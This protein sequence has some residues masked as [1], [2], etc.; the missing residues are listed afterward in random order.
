MLLYVTVTTR[1][2]FTRL[3]K[4]HVPSTLARRMEESQKL[5]ATNK[6]LNARSNP[7]PPTTQ[8]ECGIRSFHVAYI[9]PL[10]LAHLDT[11]N[12]HDGRHQGG[13]VVQRRGRSAQGGHLQIWS[14][15]MGALR[16]L[17][18]K[19]DGKAVQGAMERMAGSIDQ[20]DGVVARGR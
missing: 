10:C 6:Q 17:A 15:P 12:P 3:S 7:H 18:R 16:L 19:E 11:G 2:E 5:F 1:C 9:N 13:P 20:E 14:Q 4:A 8:A